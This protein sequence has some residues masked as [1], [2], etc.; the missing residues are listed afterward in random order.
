MKRWTLD[1][2]HRQTRLWSL[3]PSIASRRGE[4]RSLLQRADHCAR[5]TP[6]KPWPRRVAGLFCLEM[7]VEARRQCGAKLDVPW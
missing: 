3:R 7:A 1:R 5:K 4:S 6:R 2:P